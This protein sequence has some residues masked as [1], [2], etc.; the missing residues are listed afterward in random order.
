MN[1]HI[2]NFNAEQE[3]ENQKSA[4]L[5]SF[6][7]KNANAIIDCMDELLFGFTENNDFLVTKKRFSNEL[8]DYL[9]Q[10]GFNF[11]P[12]TI[13]TYLKD[14]KK[15]LMEIKNK[16]FFPY[17]VTDYTYS[18]FK[19]YRFTNVLPT[20]DSTRI[21]NSKEFST[22]INTKYNYRP[23]KSFIVKSI[24]EL[25]KAV[26]QLNQFPIII[27]EFYG[28]SGKGSLI[29]NNK[30]NYNSI[31]NYLKR[32]ENKGFCINLIVELFYE[33]ILDFSTHIKIDVKGNIDILSTEMMKNNKLVYEQSFSISKEF[34]EN[35]ESKH[36][37]EQITQIGKELFIQGYYGYAGIDSMLLKSGELIPLI[38]INARESMGLLHYFLN[39]K[40][41]TK[42][43]TSILSYLNIGSNNI[44]TIENII[45]LL[46]KNQL[47]YKWNKNYGIAI[48]S[49]NTINTN[50]NIKN[51]EYIQ[52]G[53][54]YFLIIKNSEEKNNN[55]IQKFKSLLV[56][57]NILIY[58]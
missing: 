50:Y 14:A 9:K 58:N 38:E 52:K 18:L 12:I 21:V 13:D 16:N 5:P 47:L 24:A 27:K 7:D 37:F 4:K 57:K 20:V 34:H 54:I 36:Y 48:I 39:L 35:L 55:I 30:T 26:N 49:A 10:I 11:N 6:T 46:E 45:D 22:N 23:Y 43:N 3:W 25:D 53:R 15:E 33:K 31:I 17:A 44:V 41:K 40:I 42:D 28:V 1:I 32:Q 8:K 2:G 19:K 51:E 29:I 56:S